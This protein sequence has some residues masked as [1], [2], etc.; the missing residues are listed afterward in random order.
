MTALGTVFPV[1][2]VDP[3]F[4]ILTRRR[5]GGTEPNR[6]GVSLVA[7]GVTRLQTRTW[8]GASR[9]G[10]RRASTV[11]LE[12]HI[13]SM[14]RKLR[15]EVTGV[16]VASPRQRFPRRIG[17]VRL[18]YVTDD[19]PSGAA[20]MGLSAD[21]IESDLER[22]MHDADVRAAVSPDLASRLTGTYAVRVEVLANGCDPTSDESHAGSV[23]APVAGLIG[24]LNE[25]LDPEILE[26]VRAGGTEII[27]V[28]PRAERSAE[29]RA[30]LDRFLGARGVTWQG[31]VP[32]AE[33]PALLARMGVGLTP[34]ADTLFNRASFPLKTLEYLAAGLPVVSTDLPA[35]RW[36]NTD[37]IEVG[38]DPEDFAHRVRRLLSQPENVDE[39]ARRIAF[40]RQH[41]WDA[42]ARQL[43]Q[44]LDS[45]DRA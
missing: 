21:R 6:G 3:P 34:Y 11:V 4:S 8:P 44:L 2:W 10:M 22:N 1:L 9:P 20:L 17:G 45:A 28:G 27:V 7:P 40:A 18:L 25:R 5:G 37:L 16:I 23:R 32:P 30:F 24:Q 31:E 42:R 29:T 35:V 19:W 14:V 41:S 36:L 15:L 13:R 38:L 33:L 39:T 12:R 26:A 43:L